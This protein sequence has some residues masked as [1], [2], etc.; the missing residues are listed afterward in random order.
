MPFDAEYRADHAELL[1][2]YPSTDIH[3]DFVRFIVNNFF[4]ETEEF[5]TAYYEF[6]KDRLYLIFNDYEDDTFYCITVIDIENLDALPEGEDYAI[7]A[8][9]WLRCKTEEYRDQ[10]VEQA[11]AYSF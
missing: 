9:V 3:A 11:R 6:G 7:N 4:V 2:D 10:L 5:L 1:R 8:V